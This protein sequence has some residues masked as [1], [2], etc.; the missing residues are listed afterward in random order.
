MKFDH[1][2]DLTEEEKENK[3]SEIND[4]IKILEQSNN[5]LKL[6]NNETEGLSDNIKNIILKNEDD[7]YN[8]KKEAEQYLD[9]D[10]D[11]RGHPIIK[12][13]GKNP[14]EHNKKISTGGRSTTKKKHSKKRKSKMRKLKNKRR[15]SHRRRSS[16]R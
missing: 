3:L 2:E 15:K 9:I 13:K 4:K 1:K 16:K 5:T 11:H 12:P 7:I 8:L 6:N 14:F 10:F